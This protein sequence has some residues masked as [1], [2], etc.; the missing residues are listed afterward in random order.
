MV[1][2]VGEW[3]GGGMRGEGVV[4]QQTVTRCA[5]AREEF[6][7]SPRHPRCYGPPTPTVPPPTDD[8]R[9]DVDHHPRHQPPPAERAGSPHQQYGVHRPDGHAAH[10]AG[11][12]VLQDGQL[13][14]DLVGG[15]V[16]QAP[17][18]KG[19]P[20]RGHPHVAAGD[21]G[22]ALGLGLRAAGELG[23]RSVKCC[24]VARALEGVVGL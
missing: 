22:R 5:S 21:A 16:E 1:M 3:W 4:A 17:G 14:G 19:A 15:D 13:R 24:R 10:Q 18:C 20:L 11:D 7:C 23:V 12:P 2:P 8:A 6:S 9:H